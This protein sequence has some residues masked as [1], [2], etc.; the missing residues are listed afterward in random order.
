MSGVFM[1]NQKLFLC[2]LCCG[3]VDLLNETLLT[4]KENCLNLE[5]FDLHVVVSDDSGDEFLNSKI[6]N[7]VKFLF[8][9]IC[10]SFTFRYGPNIGQAASFWRCVENIEKQNPNDNDIIFLLEEDWKFVN[11]FDLL[12]L[13][14]ILQTKIYNADVASLTL[15]CDVDNFHEYKNQGYNLVNHERF[16][17]IA[18]KELSS[19]AYI[20]GNCPHNEIICFHP[21]IIPWQKVREYKHK[22]SYQSLVHIRESAERLLGVITHG[23]RVF[24]IDNQY[25]VHTGNYRLHSVF[26]GAKIRNGVVMTNLSD[27]KANLTK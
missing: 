14:S 22:Y 15:K 9:D 1:K 23:L 8:N 19:L 25:A 12:E 16:F 2:L 21:S 24:V 6:E 18:P 5:K 20:T 17:I 7:L 26:P 11:S 13:D 4:F 27:L 10:S 3:R